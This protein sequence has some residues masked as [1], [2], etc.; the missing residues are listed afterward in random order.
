MSFIDNIKNNLNELTM[1]KNDRELKKLEA[2]YRKNVSDPSV[3]NAVEETAKNIADHLLQQ[4]KDNKIQ[5]SDVTNV[6]QLLLDSKVITNEV[7]LSVAKKLGKSDVVDNTVIVKSME[8]SK[9]NVPD[10]VIGEVIQDDNI[11]LSAKQNERALNLID[12][13]DYRAVKLTKLLKNFYNEKF[14][15]KNYMDIISRLNTLYQTLDGGQNEKIDDLCRK[16][17]AKHM[18]ANCHQFGYTRVAEYSELPFL[19]LDDMK[20]YD[21]PNL[22][23]TEYAKTYPNERN[24]VNKKQI[25]SLID[26]ACMERM[27]KKRSLNS[28]I[29][30]Y[31]KDDIFEIIFA[32][33]D[34]G[35]FKNLME[36]SRSD[37]ISVIKATANV[38]NEDKYKNASQ[39]NNKEV[40]NKNKKVIVNYDESQKQ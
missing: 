7:Y 18:A 24:K 6:L 30:Q 35:I 27:K 5:M 34:Y 40:E 19:S 14:E 36:Y 20:K 8:Q 3:D 12:D 2:S 28:V 16:I 26:R 13:S 29:S 22:V 21:L 15:K 17:V 9:V 11:Q 25:N 38:I 31:N 39:V 37:R 33:E 32:M 1:S 10:K 4:V 23:Y